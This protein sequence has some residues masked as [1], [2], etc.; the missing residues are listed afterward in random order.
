MPTGRT[1]DAGWQ[2]GVRKTI[3]RPIADVWDALTSTEGVSLW[4]G[5]G[6]DLSDEDGGY[7]TDDGQRGEVRSC[8]PKDRVRVTSRAPDADHDTTIQ[9]A[10]QEKGSKTAVVFHEERM[11][12]EAERARRKAHWQHVAG[13]LQQRLEE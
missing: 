1:K 5:D 8:R 12:S 4:L 3:E 7:E 10:V 13:R 6:A 9:I 11:A 2:V